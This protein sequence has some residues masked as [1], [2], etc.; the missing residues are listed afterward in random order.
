[1]HVFDRLENIDR[2]KKVIRKGRQRERKT[3]R[4][5]TKPHL[6]DTNFFFAAT[7]TH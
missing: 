2:G 7:K 6:T 4:E 1:M 5:E 3:R